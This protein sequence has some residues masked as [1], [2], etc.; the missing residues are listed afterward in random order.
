MTYGEVAMKAGTK[1]A[2][3]AVGSLMKANYDATIPCHRVIRSD[4]KIG[5]YNRPG[6]S[7]AKWQR[8]EEEGVD[9]RVLHL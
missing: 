6:G 3:R 7:K 4:G 1:G 9:M 5:S 8:L 2:A